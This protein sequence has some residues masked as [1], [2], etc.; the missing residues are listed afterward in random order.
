MHIQLEVA[1]VLEKEMGCRHYNY[2][3]GECWVYR[4]EMYGLELGYWDFLKY[5]QSCITQ[6]GDLKLLLR[7][8]IWTNQPQYDTTL[9]TGSELCL[10]TTSNLVLGQCLAN[11][12]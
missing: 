1:H 12:V 2:I 11:G 9:Q 6:V 4:D 8:Y 7:L 3:Q 5:A 10:P